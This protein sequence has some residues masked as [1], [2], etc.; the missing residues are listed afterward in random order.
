MSLRHSMRRHFITGLVAILPLALTIGIVWLLIEKVGGFLG[1]YLTRIPLFTNISKSLSSFL[2]FIAVIIGIYLIGLITSGFL[3]RWF[4]SQMDN[5]MA[6]L[7]FVKGLYNA[8]RQL[9]NTIFLDR[10]AFSKV[11]IIRYPWKNTYTLAFLTNEDKWKIGGKE[12]YNVFLPT[13]PN[14]TSGYYLLYPVDDVIETKMSIQ[15]GFKIIASGGIIIPKERK[16]NA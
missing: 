11:V 2:G 16:F 13:S 14:P 3:G 6:R 15:E 9:V 4:I 12:F 5:L 1:V 8:A 10:S 7:P